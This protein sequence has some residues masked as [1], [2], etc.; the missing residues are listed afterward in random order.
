MWKKVCLIGF[1]ILFLVV[2]VSVWAT[3]H[4]KLFDPVNLGIIFQPE[5]TEEQA[6]EILKDYDYYI[7]SLSRE[8]EVLKDNSQVWAFLIVNKTKGY[9]LENKFKKIEEVESATLEWFSPV[10]GLKSYLCSF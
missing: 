8:K 7:F 3:V 4:Y 9:F 1:G 2:G 5:V 6:E 10:A